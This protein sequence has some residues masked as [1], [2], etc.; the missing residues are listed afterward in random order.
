MVQAGAVERRGLAIR[1]PHPG[2]PRHLRLA[3]SRCHQ[4]GREVLRGRATL[5]RLSPSFFA[6]DRTSDEVI[7]LGRKECRCRGSSVL[8][9]DLASFPCVNRFSVSPLLFH[10]KSLA[11]AEVV[12]ADQGKTPLSRH[13]DVRRWHRTR[14]WAYLDTVPIGEDFVLDCREYPE[15]SSGFVR[16]SNVGNRR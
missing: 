15:A 4:A 14:D 7:C 8:C 16:Y 12:L 6:P 1:S 5:G 3:E 11:A 9:R 10:E 13:A 2:Y